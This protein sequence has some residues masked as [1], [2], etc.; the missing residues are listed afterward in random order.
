MQALLQALMHSTTSMKNKPR[1]YSILLL[2]LVFLLA[3]SVIGCSQSETW[4]TYRNPTYGYTIAYP[5][6]WHLDTSDAPDMVFI[7]SPPWCLDCP[8]CNIAIDAYGGFSSSVD[9]RKNIMLYSVRDVYGDFEDF[10]FISSHALDG[11]YEWVIEFTYTAIGTKCRGKAYTG[12]TSD[13]RFILYFAS[14]T[15]DYNK[16]EEIVETFIP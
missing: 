2:G 10:E 13:Y 1:L 7:D 4:T 9:E 12:E 14:I 11:K 16:C 6:N 3:S 15:E 5:Q 8:V